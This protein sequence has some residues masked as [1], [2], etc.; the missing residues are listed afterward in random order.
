LISER[1]RRLSR[2]SSILF[3]GAGPVSAAEALERLV[4]LD[5]PRRRQRR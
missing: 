4:A 2:R 1:V 3:I 5:E